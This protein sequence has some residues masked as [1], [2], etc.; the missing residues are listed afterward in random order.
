MATLMYRR[1][2]AGVGDWQGLGQPVTPMTEKDIVRSVLAAYVSTATKLAGDASDA[3]KAV[4]SAVSAR[5]QLIKD[6]GNLISQKAAQA[7]AEAASAGGIGGSVASTIVYAMTAA[8]GMDQ[9]SKFMS[10]NEV[11]KAVKD[12]YNQVA[13]VLKRTTAAWYSFKNLRMDQ[14]EAAVF[15]SGAIDELA[16]RLNTLLKSSVFTADAIRMQAVV[17]V[18]GQW[19]NALGISSEWNAKTSEAGSKIT[20]ALASLDSTLRQAGPAIDAEANR[21][22]GTSEWASDINGL[23]GTA[24]AQYLGVLKAEA[25]KGLANEA[26]VFET[27]FNTAIRFIKGIM[28]YAGFIFGIVPG[29]FSYF[30]LSS[31]NQFSALSKLGYTAAR[32]TPVVMKGMEAWTTSYSSTFKNERLV[33]KESESSAQATAIA[34]ADQKSEQVVGAEAAAAREEARRYQNDFLAAKEAFDSVVGAGLGLLK[35]ILLYGGLALGGAIALY[36]GIPEV[37]KKL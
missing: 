36:V 6:S 30:L 25:G 10:E 7:S 28:P 22:P 8:D 34:V 23:V 16:D 27:Y 12:S 20:S 17:T 1:R 31:G 21:I 9:L 26:G 2:R 37:I 3:G 33:K 13:D 29:V 18:M 24:Q 4:S 5:S 35:D 14:L 11:D 15:P 19:A 32:W